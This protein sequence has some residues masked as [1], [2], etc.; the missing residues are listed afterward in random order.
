[1]KSKF[2]WLRILFLSVAVFAGCGDDDGGGV[3]PD[4][5]VDSVHRAFVTDD[6]GRALILHGLNVSSSAK[7]HPQRMPWIDR[8]QASRIARDWGFNGV[9]FLIFWDAVEPEP[10]VYDDAYLDL[11]A[12][13]VGWLTDAGIYVIL[14]MHQ[15]VYGKYGVDGRRLGFDGAPSW[16]ARTDGLPHRLA[17]PWALTYVQPGVRRAFDN[18]WDDEGPNADLQAHYAAMWAHVA[19]R[20]AGQPRV[21]GYNLMNEPYAG[22]A[23]A[24]NLGGIPFG[25]KVAAEAFQKAAFHRF[26]QR[27]I[28]AIRAVDADSWIF[29]EPLAFSVNN[30]GTNHLPPLVD[31][32]PGEP[33]LVYYPH[34]YSIG[35]EISNT[36]DPDDDPERDAWV[37]ERPADLEAYGAPMMVGEFGMNWRGNGDPLGYLDRLCDVFDDLT[38]GWMYWSHDIGGWSLVEGEDLHENPNVDVLV[39]AYPQRVAGFPVE[40]GYDADTREMHLVFADRAAAKGPTEIYVPEARHYPDGWNLAVDAPEGSW[41]STWDAEREVLSVTIEN[42]GGVHEIRITPR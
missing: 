41:S 16:A 21:L 5:V 20:F 34:L 17:E 35:P 32:R 19:Q 31:P 37:A 18:F 3:P 13:R 11:V 29:F 7:D 1:M 42:T 6:D 14:D 10:G 22:S 2:S 28:D 23:A 30:G 26:N 4:P 24:G 25:D 9:R 12:E 27:M 15:D 39:R 36:F 38:S 40:Y 8:E 33:R